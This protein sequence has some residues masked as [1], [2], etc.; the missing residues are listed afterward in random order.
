MNVPTFEEWAAKRGQDTE[1][2][3]AVAEFLAALD[4]LRVG[5]E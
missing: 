4:A 2:A 1:G 5:A 3:Q